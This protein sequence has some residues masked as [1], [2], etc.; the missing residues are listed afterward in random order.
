MT[1]QE[2]TN[3]LDA[4]NPVEMPMAE[5]LQYAAAIAALAQADALTRIAAVMEANRGAVEREQ[6]WQATR[7]LLDEDM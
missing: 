4:L 7:E 1:V 3:M 2:M 5:A 6:N